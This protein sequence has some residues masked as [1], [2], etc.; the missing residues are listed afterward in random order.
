LAA[1]KASPY[2]TFPVTT[3]SIGHSGPAFL[4]STCWLKNGLA[5]VV[6]AIEQIRVGASSHSVSMKKSALTPEQIASVSCPTCG[7][8]ARKRCLLNSGLPRSESHVDRKFAAIE[9]IE[10][11]LAKSR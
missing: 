9:S 1:G 8:S 11:N 7:V 2:Q 10:K 6:C 3:S 4:Q 5:M